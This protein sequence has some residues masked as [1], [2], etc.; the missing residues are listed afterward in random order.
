MV[1][2]G[3]SDKMI[4]ISKK[5]INETFT[6]GLVVIFSSLFTEEFHAHKFATCY[7]LL[8]NFDR[9]RKW[10]RRHEFK[11]WTRLIAFHLALIPLGKV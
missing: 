4:K 6:T 10:T 2:F 8:Y 11:S 1:D 3:E 7:I 5:L 9:C